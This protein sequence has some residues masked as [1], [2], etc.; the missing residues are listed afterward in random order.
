MGAAFRNCKTAYT[1]LNGTGAAF[2]FVQL[3]EDLDLT[4]KS[5]GRR[6]YFSAAGK[7][8][9]MVLKAYSNLSDGDL[10]SQL[11]VNLHYSWF[12]GVHF[13]SLYYSRMTFGPLGF[14]FFEK[15]E[16]KLRF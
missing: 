10:I 13:N 5:R 11:N 15:V 8:A 6:S 4:D 16:Q 3:G 7:V 12:C 2:P 1:E 14:Y 9:P